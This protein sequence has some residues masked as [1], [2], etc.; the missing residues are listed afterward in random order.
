MLITVECT[1]PSSHKPCMILSPL[2]Q[3]RDVTHVTGKYRT[4]CMVLEFVVIL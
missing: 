3:V 2:S 4:L 1:Y